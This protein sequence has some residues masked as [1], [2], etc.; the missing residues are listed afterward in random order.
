LS[1]STADFFFDFVLAVRTP[2]SFARENFSSFLHRERL[3]G[4]SLEVSVKA[5]KSSEKFINEKLWLDGVGA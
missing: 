2:Q 4:Q 3:L 5:P 1:L